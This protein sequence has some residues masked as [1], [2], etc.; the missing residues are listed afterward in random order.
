MMNEEGYIREQV[1]T[2]NPFRVP[3]NYFEHFAD[4][5]MQQLPERQK[6]S[7][8]VALR[9]WLMAAAC[10]VAVVVMSLTVLFNQ[11]PTEGQMAANNE[12]ATYMDEA[13]DYAML[14]NAEIYACLADY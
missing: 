14:D 7:R 10:L 5:V 11:Q 4:R 2:G 6:K 3:D 12:T 8:L 13:A 1:G 9:P